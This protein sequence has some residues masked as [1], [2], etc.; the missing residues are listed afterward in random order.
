V[1]FN[2]ENFDQ[3]KASSVEAQS[4]DANLR[5]LANQ[6]VEESNKYDYAYHWTW[7]GLPII[8]LPEDILVT[9]EIIWQK[10]PDLIIE[11]GIAWGGSVILHAAM[12]EL[13]GKGEVVAIDSSLP[14]H[15]KTEISKY[16]FS[17]RIKL[18]EGNSISNETLSEVRKH[19]A[20]QKSVAVFLDSNHTHEHVLNEL[21][22]YGSM[23]T[24]DQYLTVYGTA[25]ENMPSPEHRKRLWGAGNSPLS[26]IRTYLQESDRFQIDER[27][28]RLS[29]CTFALN[30]RLK[31]IR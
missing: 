26:A 9:Q 18:I 24:V 7:L 16:H 12:L 13:I 1:T 15:V 6:F 31:C 4:N 10:K 29:L 2:R 14:A 5:A 20:P 3:K 11:T 8:Q 25:I 21:R 28:D 23:V 19:L 27:L 30:G 17:K 22:A